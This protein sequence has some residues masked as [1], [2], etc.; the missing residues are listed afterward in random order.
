MFAIY[1]RV[2]DSRVY[3]YSMSSIVFVPGP[4]NPA[5]D[6]ETVITVPSFAEGIPGR[7]HPT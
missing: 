6:V 1:V 4:Y 3:G 5:D 2:R 7:N